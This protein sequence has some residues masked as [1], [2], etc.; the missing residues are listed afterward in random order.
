MA[1]QNHEENSRR[2]AAGILTAAILVILAGCATSPAPNPRSR[3]MR[4]YRK[5]YHDL[6]PV[7]RRE[8]LSGTFTSP[9]AAEQ[10]LSRFA[11]SNRERSALLGQRNL[12]STQLEQ[13]WRRVDKFLA[14]AE[15]SA[16]A[17]AKNPAAASE[18]AGKCAG[19]ADELKRAESQIRHTP[20]DASRRN[21]LLQRNSYYASRVQALSKLLSKNK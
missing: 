11:R 21:A 14:E 1:L 4:L 18:L 17:A 19:F 16:A 5:Y 2:Q 7:Q 15:S 3:R 10:Q 12:K 9:E 8:F 20:Y 13:L 6:T